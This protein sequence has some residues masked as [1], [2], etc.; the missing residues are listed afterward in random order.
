MELT[1]IQIMFIGLL[2]TALSQII[3]LISAK[4]GRPIGRKVITIVLAFVSLVVAWLWSNPTLIFPSDP[5]ALIN[6]L[7]TLAASVVGFAVMIY[8][9]LLSDVAEKTDLTTDVILAKETEKHLSD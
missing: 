1:A 3:K 5:M 4:L 9:L 6:Y 2:A 7:I 8:N